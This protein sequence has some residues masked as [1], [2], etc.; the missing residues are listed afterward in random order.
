MSNSEHKKF[1]LADN[2]KAI[3]VSFLSVVL[4][5]AA[6]G[7]LMFSVIKEHEKDRAKD[8]LSNV[9]M[10]FKDAETALDY[11]NA[12]PYYSC[13][14]DNLNE[15]RRTLFRS[16]FVKEIGFFGDGKLLCSTYLGLLKQ[17]IDEAIPDFVT[18]LGD[19]FW[20]NTPLELF[21]NQ[22]KGTIAKRGRY[23]AVLDMDAVI[24]LNF[25]QDWALFYKADELFHM[26]GNA[27]LMPQSAGGGIAK[28]DTSYFSLSLIKCDKYYSST[29][30]SVVSDQGRIFNTHKGKL[31]LFVCVMLM[32]AALSHMLTFN[33]LRRRR[34]LE[35]RISRG[36][37]SGKFYC[38]YQPF[39][40]LKSGEVVG[41]EVLSRFED[42]FGPIY[43]DEFIPQVKE[44]GKTWEFTTVM[45]ESAMIALNENKD[46]PEGFKVS[47]NLFPSDFMK[48]E[49][50]DLDW[51]LTMND[52][53]FKLVLEITEDEQL[54]TGSAVKHIKALK[55]RGFWMAIDDFGVG[56][57]NLSQ[58]KSLKCEFLKIDRSFVMDMED[59]SIR[60]SLIPHIVS[61]ADELRVTLIAEGVENTDQ[62]QELVNMNVEYGQGWLFGKPQTVENLANTI[63]LSSQTH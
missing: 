10:V 49:L 56:Y 55:S 51:V 37:K 31:V 58:L 32:T 8:I 13:S 61:I 11:L 62:C 40:I 63:E 7:L 26:A 6:L 1:L 17:P 5:S 54:A 3:A 45:I 19:A 46:I 42:E 53:N 21:D 48:D 50:L 30:L 34:S 28:L 36:L 35:S 20:I 4:V 15:M 14:E 25:S 27:S 52:K 23:N 18:S 60:S 57:S 22:S 29:C 2:L 33:Y 43:P 39:V 38:L 41:C 12:S 24:G 47:F 9:N 59:H 16:R 44:L